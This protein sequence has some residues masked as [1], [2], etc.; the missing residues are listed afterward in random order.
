[1]EVAQRAASGAQVVFGKVSAAAVPAAS[2]LVPALV[3]AGGAAK[4]LFDLIKFEIFRDFFQVISIFFTGLKEKLDETSFKA[5]W[6]NISELWSICFSCW[7]A[8]NEVAINTALF[9]IKFAIAFITCVYFYYKYYKWA[10]EE[11]AGLEA[12]NVA[13]ADKDERTYIK[14]SVT[15]LTSL[16]LPV[17]R[18]VIQVFT[19]DTELI[20]GVQISIDPAPK[21]FAEP[22][23]YSG[24]HG[25]MLVLGI[26]HLIVY[27]L[28][29]PF[30]FHRI[31]SKYKPQVSLYDEEGKIRAGDQAYTD[32]DYKR[33][34]AKDANPYKSLYEGYER[35]WAFYK[36]LV[37]VFKL[38][39]IVPTTLLVV[40]NRFGGYYDKDANPDQSDTNKLLLIQSIIVIVIL[41]IYSIF[42][43]SSRPFLDD[44][45]DWLDS[46]SRGTTLVIAI[47]GL[48]ISVV[49][50]GANA[51]GIVLNVLS[52][53]SASF[54]LFTFLKSSGP[55]HRCLKSCRQTVDFA[56]SRTDPDTPLV[57]S[58]QLDLNRERKLRIWH[59]FWDTIFS[60][61]T[62]M[63]IP[64]ENKDGEDY[65]AKQAAYS[66]GRTPPY[67]LNFSGTVQERHEEN[68]TIASHESVLSY[69][70]ALLIYT[71]IPANQVPLLQGDIRT[72]ILS[73]NGVDV[74]WAC[75][76]EGTPEG[77]QGQQRKRTLAQ[78]G[79]AMK[80]GKLFIVPFPF[81][82]VIAFDDC[83]QIAVISLSPIVNGVE[84]DQ[85]QG[86]SQFRELI[87]SNFDS[88]VLR[89]KG[90]R[91]SL[92]ALSGNSIYYF[93]QCW[94]KKTKSRQVTK[95]RTN[96]QGQSE[97]YTDTETYTVDVF[98]T[99]EHGTFTVGTAKDGATWTHPSTG[100]TLDMNRGFAAQL[101][102]YDGHGVDNEGTAWNNEQELLPAGT[103][104]IQSDFAMTENLRKVMGL[105]GG[106]Y[107]PNAIPIERNL[108]TIRANYQIYRE[109][110]FSEFQ[111]KESVLSYAFW[112][113]VYNNDTLPQQQL[114][115]ILT[116]CER[117]DLIRA[118]PTENKV[119]FE[120]VYQKLAYF[121]SHPAVGYWFTFWHDFYI[122]NKDL[123]VVKNNEA[124]F[125][126][127]SSLSIC[128][129]FMDRKA[130]EEFLGK[131]GLHGAV[132]C[133]GCK[134]GFVN[135][136]M[137]DRIYGRIAT[138]DK[139][140]EEKKAEEQNY[141]KM[142]ELSSGVFQ[143]RDNVQ[144]I[145]VDAQGNLVQ[146]QSQQ[147]QIVMQVNAQPQVVVQ[148]AP[149]Q[150][151]VEVQA[152]P[153]QPVVDLQA[154]PQVVM[155][156]GQPIDASM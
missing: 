73:L 93:Y 121:N 74:W 43:W 129:K 17:A 107:A 79:S 60:Q 148:Q 153:T 89:R 51:F 38:F 68:K 10:P 113:Y 18:D 56:K 120:M 37:M 9:F 83:D 13:M 105:A 139:Q 87:R 70:N 156:M 108:P 147:T 101:N 34:L 58:P 133:C 111:R 88:E 144:V 64:S 66:S 77:K 145:V 57:F 53:V 78:N 50:G 32:D 141:L 61:D 72:A 63:R 103:I 119:D 6:G 76:A 99:F 55:V 1:M 151:V 152:Q 127:Y 126:P 125:S 7:F 12:K 23:C 150:Q 5:F 102:L 42:S 124:D 115:S 2:A 132:T 31:I 84:R 110:Y 29:T 75:E 33:D 86:M 96:A 138:Y 80:F 27:L 92:R 54:M 82:A 136:G 46:L 35:K 67:L 21:K 100:L 155:S 4:A 59:E 71:K 123:E 14:W 24:T 85:S 62:K 94:K 39:L 41:V 69:E 98:F 128:Y 146:Q 122:F 95:T 116:Q 48:L 45:D 143:S 19:C 30:L 91:L 90:V 40:S 65:A 15:I 137:L 134:Q 106:N 28:P 140:A 97:T 131:H 20:S 114:F 25:F 130:A 49:S 154:Q 11:A 117:N 149:V 112:Y 109:F 142:M 22:A 135:D 104:G 16:F 81:T 36:V 3:A 26:V 8:D 52:A 118:L 47:I 44:A